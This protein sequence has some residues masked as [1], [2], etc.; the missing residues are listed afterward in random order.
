MWAAE[1]TSRRREQEAALCGGQGPKGDAG[2]GRGQCRD[3]V[4]GEHVHRRQWECHERGPRS[5]SGAVTGYRQHPVWASGTPTR[6][7]VFSHCNLS[8]AEH[9]TLLPLLLLLSKTPW[10]SWLG[11]GVA[12][13]DVAVE[14]VSPGLLSTCTR[15]HQISHELFLLLSSLLLLS[16]FMYLFIYKYTSTRNYC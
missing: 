10:A 8:V 1:R 15:A 2:P 13:G 14:G 9:T 11:I 7:G 6:C 5:P 16:L 4:R 3:R 12:C